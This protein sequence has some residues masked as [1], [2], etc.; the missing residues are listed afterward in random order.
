[1]DG[2]KNGAQDFALSDCC[3][4]LGQSHSSQKSDTV[5]WTAKYS[6]TSSR[7]S[8]LLSFF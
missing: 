5:Y 8:S 4:V 2:G 3:S 6:V 1:M 7:S